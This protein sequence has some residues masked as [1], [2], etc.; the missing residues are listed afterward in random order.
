MV[1]ILG[2]KHS[3]NC[4][5]E[6]SASCGHQKNKLASRFE[7]TCQIYS[8]ANK[9]LPVVLNLI[10]QEEELSKVMEDERKKFEAQLQEKLAEIE[11]IHK[12]SFLYE[13]HTKY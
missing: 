13:L 1:C 4:Y 8:S 10:L 6:S 3:N 12:V 9:I 11:N 2:T 7:I 5:F